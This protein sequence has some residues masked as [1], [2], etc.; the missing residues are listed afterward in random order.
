MRF[1]TPSLAIF[2]ESVTRNT[3]PHI[4]NDDLRVIDCDYRYVGH[5][6]KPKRNK[7]KVPG[8]VA[9]LRVSTEEQA[10]SGLGL[11]A[12]ESAIRA[13]CAKRGVDLVAVHTDAGIS[14]KS[15]DRLSRS[16]HDASGLMLRAE[17]AGWGLVALDLAVDTTTA[18]GKGHGAD[19]VRVRRV[20]EAAQR[21]AYEGSVG[22]QA[23]R[24]A[25]ASEPRCADA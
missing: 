16:V 12:Q 15:L 9:H 1:S 5:I 18:S 19:D 20:G 4:T 13:E 17:K 21:R 24:S 6:G 14:G 8:V 23:V 10:E 22:H 25:R 3:R 2:S 11:A 7:D